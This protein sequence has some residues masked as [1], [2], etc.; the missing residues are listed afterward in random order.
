MLSNEAR[1]NTGTLWP[2]KFIKSLKLS[3]SRVLNVLWLSKLSSPS[4]FSE[5]CS[6]TLCFFNGCP[7]G[8]M[9]FDKLSFHRDD[10][11]RNTRV[12]ISDQTKAKECSPAEQFGVNSTH[13]SK[14]RLSGSKFTLSFSLTTRRQLGE[15]AR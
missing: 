3:A 6:V 10:L 2:E 12:K 11:F 7:P 14:Q 1:F 13:C 4:P 8:K 15:E 9:Y 5:R